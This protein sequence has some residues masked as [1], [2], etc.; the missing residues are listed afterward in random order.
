VSALIALLAGRGRSMRSGIYRWRKERLSASFLER[1][2]RSHF[3]E[4]RNHTGI[5]LGT[6]LR[7]APRNGPGEPSLTRLDCRFP[8]WAEVLGSERLT[9]TLPTASL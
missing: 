6:P 7:S 3:H 1:G 5:E 8:E 9:G 4:Q 2:R